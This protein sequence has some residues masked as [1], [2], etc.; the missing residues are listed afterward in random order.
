VTS[1]SVATTSDDDS[2][3]DSP[4]EHSDKAMYRAKQA[5]RNGYSI[6][7]GPAA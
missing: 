5:G 7:E 1:V 4:R 3:L 2:D 6:H